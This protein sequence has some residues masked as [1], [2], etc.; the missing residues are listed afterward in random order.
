VVTDELVGT[1]GSPSRISDLNI[2]IDCPRL[3]AMAGSFGEQQDTDDNDGHND[4]RFA[5][6]SSHGRFLPERLIDVT[7]ASPEADI[8]ITCRLQDPRRADYSLSPA[9]A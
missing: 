6:Q 8:D 1:S 5:E 2:R 4:P 3:R 7:V 9:D